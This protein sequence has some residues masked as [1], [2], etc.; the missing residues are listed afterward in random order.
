MGE[1]YYRTAVLPQDLA[2]ISGMKLRQSDINEL[3]AATPAEPMDALLESVKSSSLLW[4]AEKD[5]KIEAVFGVGNDGVFNSIGIP[6]LLATDEFTKHSYRVA[7]R[8]R[9]IVEK[10]LEQYPLL[11][12]FVANSNEVSKKWL[13]WLG[14]K[15]E[16]DFP[17]KLYSETEIFIP[18]EM[19]R[20]RKT[21]V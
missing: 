21:D 2:N 12:N 3:R 17:I 10:M 20:R 14:F 11:L 5:G 4:V 7:R 6:W 15:L 9:E 16:P 13:K 19:K 18:F 8:S 1:M